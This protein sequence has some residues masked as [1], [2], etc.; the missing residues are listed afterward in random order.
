MLKRT[1][2]L[3]SLI[4]SLQKKKL[5][6]NQIIAELKSNYNITISEKALLKRLKLI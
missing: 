6:I 1:D 3:S 4:K 2:Y 5:S